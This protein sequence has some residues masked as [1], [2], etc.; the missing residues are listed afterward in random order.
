MFRSRELTQKI[1][2]PL[3][4]RL[5]LSSM[6]L[7]LYTLILEFRGGTYILNYWLLRRKNRQMCAPSPLLSLKQKRGNSTCRGFNVSPELRTS[8]VETLGQRMVCPWKYRKAHC[9]A[10]YRSDGLLLS[11]N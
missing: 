10:D 2:W 1:V 4:V 9:F 6:G 3:S 8:A 5:V 7:M 11:R